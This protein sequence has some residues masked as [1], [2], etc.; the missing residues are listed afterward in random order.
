[1]SV[2]LKNDRCDVTIVVPYFKA[3]ATLP[4]AL[5]SILKQTFESWE[6]ILIN[7]GSPEDLNSVVKSY[8]DPRIRLVQ[9]EK[10]QGRGYTRQHGLELAQGKYICMVDADD[11]IYPDKIK[12]QFEWLESN[13]NISILSSSMAIVDTRGQLC[14]IRHYGKNEDVSI[15]NS[16]TKLPAVLPIPHAPSMIKT[17]VALEYGYDPS[18]RM[19]EDYQFLLRILKSH[20]FA[21]MNKPLYVY[22]EI[23]TLSL[24]KILQSLSNGYKILSDVSKKESQ[25]SKIELMKF[26]LKMIAYP[27]IYS[28][29]LG[30]VSRQISMNNISFKERSEFESSRRIVHG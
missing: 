10:N 8:N 25:N 20:A 12:Y 27:L 1:M 18:L 7:D 23:S 19:S 11:W 6:C 9:W 21:V 16:L 17:S 24:Q 2:V 3:Q 30:R 14:G 29:R 26:K 5:N 22:T 4:T 13:K 15:F 28:L